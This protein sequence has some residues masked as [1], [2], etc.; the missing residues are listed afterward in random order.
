M[1]SKLKYSFSLLTLFSTRMIQIIKLSQYLFLTTTWIFVVNGYTQEID[2]DKD[3][4]L[5][6]NEITAFHGGSTT[7]STLTKKTGDVTSNAATAS[8][9]ATKITSQLRR[10]DKN[11]DNALLNKNQ[12]DG[13]NKFKSFNDMNYWSF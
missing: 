13:T 10:D 1:S 3:G 7:T 9:R 4:Q 5:E 6:A 2:T 8:K 11:K 12:H